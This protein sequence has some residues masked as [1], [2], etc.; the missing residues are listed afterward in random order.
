MLVVYCLNETSVS[1]RLPS[2]CEKPPIQGLQKTNL[3]AVNSGQRFYYK[4]G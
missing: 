2:P 4:S 1:P 3:H